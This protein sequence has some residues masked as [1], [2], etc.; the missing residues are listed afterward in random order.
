[1]KLTFCSSRA[2]RGGTLE[3]GPLVSICQRSRQLES[4]VVSRHFA[5][6]IRCHDSRRKQRPGLVRRRALK[7]LR[8]IKKLPEHALAAKDR[9]FD[10]I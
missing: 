2:F 4:S 7:V 9:H 8:R 6:V 10:F 3:R 5:H 1:M